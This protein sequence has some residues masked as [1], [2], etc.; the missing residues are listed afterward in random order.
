[1]KVHVWGSSDQADELKSK[2][3]KVLEELWLTDFVNIESSSDEEM[4]TNMNITEESALIIEEE[5]ISFKDMIF[6]WMVPEEEE[7]KSMF[8]SIIWGGSWWG[9]APEGCGSWCS[10]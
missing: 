2:I 7:L 1:M 3:Q 8:V 4:K 6:E 10:C 9:C 5:S